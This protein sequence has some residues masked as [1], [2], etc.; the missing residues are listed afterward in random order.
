MLEPATRV[1]P[2]PRARP[3]AGPVSEEPAAELAL[4]AVLALVVLSLA[5]RPLVAATGLPSVTRNLDGILV[6]FAALAVVVAVLRRRALA[7]RPVV[8]ATALLVALG[9]VT[10]LSWVLASPHGVPALGLGFACV[11]L[12]PLA[13]Y[14]GAVAVRARRSRVDVVVLQVAVLAQLAAGMVQYV[15]HHVAQR[16]P[17]AADLVNG[18]TSHN[19]WPA[20]A[21]PG[22]IVLAVLERGWRRAAWPLSVAV[23]GVYAE[24]KAA[25]TLWVPVL[26]VV[27]VVGAVLALRARGG[28]PRPGL[29]GAVGAALGTAAAAVVVGG[30]WFTPSAQGTWQVFEGHTHEIEVFAQDGPDHAVGGAPATIKDALR[31]VGSAVPGSARTLL[32]GLGPGNS[33][34]HAA[35]VL[36]QG[37]ANGA[38]VTPP[39]PVALELLRSEGALQFEDA[40]SSVLGVWG[41]LGT[42]GALLWVAAVASAAAALVAVVARASGRVLVLLGVA[43]LVLGPLA[44]SSLLDWTEQASVELPV[45][46]AAVVL[47]RH[48]P[49][50][51]ERP[52][53]GEGRAPADGGTAA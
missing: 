30:L 3:A 11:L 16:A 39:G 17:Y 41:D 28:L 2:P 31:V 13:L 36:A 42:L 9:A 7:S 8:V 32:L 40:Q 37:P 49:L 4:R 33:V 15:E 35:E 22:A 24:A 34:S 14:L 45:V 43:A 44:A 26:V 10:L 51:G 1:A 12:L 53:P 21:L 52:A 19:L 6:P 47:V 46:L 23:L 18:T 25:L 48:A 20:F 29:Q 27:A 5:V 38:S 50:G